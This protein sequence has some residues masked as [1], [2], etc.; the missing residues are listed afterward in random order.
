MH[1][2][3]HVPS[4]LLAIIDDVFLVNTATLYLTNNLFSMAINLLN[5]CM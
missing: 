4:K 1:Q 5:T 2:V 3:M